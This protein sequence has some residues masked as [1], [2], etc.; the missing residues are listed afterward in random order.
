MNRRLFAAA[1]AVAALF[2]SVDSAFAGSPST[3]TVRIK[4]V[5]AAP[6]AVFAANGSPTESQV[7]AGY[8]LISPNG[9]AQ[10]VIKQGA[11]VGVA[12][13]PR[14]GQSDTQLRRSRH[15]VLNWGTRFQGV[16]SGFWG[17]TVAAQPPARGD[18]GEGVAAL[19]CSPVPRIFG[20]L[21]RGVVG[22]GATW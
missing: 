20:D 14:R 10:F 4:N 2:L 1:V 19:P 7:A 3:Q 13:D 6:V 22:G 12:V 15:P 17:C 21:P 5:G 18:Y 9:V 11:A 16:S 8:K